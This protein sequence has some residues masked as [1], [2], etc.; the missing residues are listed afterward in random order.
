MPLP[1]VTVRYTNGATRT[2]EP[3]YAEIL[4]K[5]GKAELVDGKASKP[6]RRYKRR[7]MRA[8]TE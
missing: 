5:I 4:V 2:M 8:E 3:R 7:D 1:Q 6:K